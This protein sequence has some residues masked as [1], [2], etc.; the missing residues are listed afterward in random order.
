MIT[1]FR[2]KELREFFETHSKRGIPAELATRLR[3]RLDVLDAASA[4]DDLSLPHFDLHELKGDRA[5]TWV[6]KVNK[7]WRLT[8]TFANGDAS[9]VNFE[10]YH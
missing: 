1:S 8:F 7:N 6:L 3:D 4:I 9:G 5:G 10:D 2:H